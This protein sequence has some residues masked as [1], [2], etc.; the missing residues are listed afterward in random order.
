[1]EKML[2]K[3]IKLYDDKKYEEALEIFDDIAYKSEDINIKVRAL[4]YK[5]RSQIELKKFDK[6]FDTFNGITKDYKGDI[7][8]ENMLIAAR[9]L[10]YEPQTSQFSHV[11]YHLKAYIDYSKIEYGKIEKEA[12][13]YYTLALIILKDPYGKKSK[14]LEYIQKAIELES[15]NKEYHEA[16]KEIQDTYDN[17][18]ESEKTTIPDEISDILTRLKAPCTYIEDC[19]IDDGTTPDNWEEGY[20]Y[21]LGIN[22]NKYVGLPESIERIEVYCMDYE[23]DIKYVKRREPFEDCTLRNGYNLPDYYILENEYP[24]E[25]ETI[26]KYLKNFTYENYDLLPKYRELIEKFLGHK[27]SLNFIGGYINPFYAQLVNLEGLNFIMQGWEYFDD[28]NGYGD[29]IFIFSKKDNPKDLLAMK[30]VD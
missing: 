1:M 18:L 8:I 10:Y 11:V 4:N 24:K 19:M 30:G 13:I 25:Y 9:G 15:N 2:E 27:F 23:C 7:Y 12:E 14:S 29:L 16:L 22:N 3:A 26:N 28:E 5:G 20:H 17:S 21:L 6:A